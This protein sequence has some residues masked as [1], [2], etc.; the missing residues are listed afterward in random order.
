MIIIPVNLLDSYKSGNLTLAR[1]WRIK[2]V[3]GEVFG[4][5]NFEQDVVFNGITY[6]S[7]VGLET[8]AVNIESSLNVDNL[9]LVGVINS[10]SITEQSLE[11]GLWDSAEVDIFEFDYMKGV[12]AGVFIV[13]SGYM[14]DIKLKQFTYNSQ[15]RGITLPLQSESGRIF[16]PGCGWILGDSNCT[17]NLEEYKKSFISDGTEE[18]RN[19]LK[20]NNLTEN[21]YQGGHVKF[22]SGNNESFIIEIKENSDNLISLQRA[23]PFNLENGDTFDIYPGC[24]KTEETCYNKYN[25][26]KNFGGFSDI[27]DLSVFT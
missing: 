15:I 11:M 13:I 24:N 18:R 8:T 23:Y 12:Q 7:N 20:V 3:D 10:D 1:L 25:N 22:T 2:R 16:T 27:K 6:Q 14:G 21:Y 17:V 4:F 5:T 19:Q 9:D 26:M